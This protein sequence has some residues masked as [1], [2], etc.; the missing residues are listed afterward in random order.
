MLVAAVRLQGSHCGSVSR[1]EIAG[2]E[3]RCRRTGFERELQDVQFDG[4]QRRSWQLSLSKVSF[5]CLSPSTSLPSPS[6]L[7][8]RRPFCRAQ[9]RRESSDKLN[10]GILARF[11]CR[12]VRSLPPRTAKPQNTASPIRTGQTLHLNHLLQPSVV[13]RA[14]VA[15]RPS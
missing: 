13:L 7:R 15:A 5:G 6:L 8:R 9:E 11:S 4:V 1:E 3:I 10:L 14:W 12:L 2:K